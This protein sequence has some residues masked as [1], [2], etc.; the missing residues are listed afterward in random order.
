MIKPQYIKRNCYAKTMQTPTTPTNI[1]CENL[2]QHVRIIT[3][4]MS[5]KFFLCCVSFLKC[6]FAYLNFN[7]ELPHDKLSFATIYRTFAHWTEVF[8]TTIANENFV[9]IRTQIRIELCK[10]FQVI[11]ILWLIFFHLNLSIHI[12]YHFMK[13]LPISLL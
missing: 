12:N 5:V 3:F 11:L 4:T 1:W 2:F 13:N 10:C 7:F 6:L 9:E 8:R